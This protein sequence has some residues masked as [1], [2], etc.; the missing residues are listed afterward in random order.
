MASTFSVDVWDKSPCEAW[1]SEDHAPGTWQW[2]EDVT[3]WRYRIQP[4]IPRFAMFQAWAG[5]R[6]LDFGCGIGTDTLEFQKY[7]AAVVGMDTS[8]AS[9]SLAR[10]RHHAITWVNDWS[11]V[12]GSF[13]LVYSFGVLHHCYYPSLELSMIRNV[14]TE[15]S[16][17]KAMVYHR[18]SWK[19]LLRQQPE[20]SPDISLVRWYTKR[21][22]KRMIEAAGFEVTSME[23][24][25]IFPW[26]WQDYR[27][28]QLVKAWPWNH[29][30]HEKWERWL[31]HHL[32]VTARTI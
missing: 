29:I 7:G 19:W 23:V 30:N 2:S 24:A 15:S 12:R 14:M 26:R 20:A 21:E 5:K 10:R 27:R 28:F 22:A 25:H 32:L 1:H 3:R 4:H 6:V 8:L 11:D 13:D 18:P 9:L 31:G 17:L 16:T